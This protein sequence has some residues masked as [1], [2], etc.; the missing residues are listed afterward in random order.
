M[1]ARH[2]EA[3]LQPPGIGQCPAFEEEHDV[4]PQASEG[5]YSVRSVAR[6]LDLLLEL[7]ACDRPIGLSEL[8]RRAKLHPTT[9]LR[10]L[11]T[12]RS[13]GFAQQSADRSYVLG[14][15]TFE[16]GSAFL[17]NVSIWSQATGLVERLAAV[18]EETAS[19]GVLDEGQVLYIA[20][21]RGQRDVGI[22]SAPGSR[23]PLYCTSLGKAILAEL[24]VEVTD[25]LLEEHP[26]QRLSAN[27]IVDVDAF[28]RELAVI[29][30]RGYAVDD[31]E[32]TPGVVCVGASVHDH[33]GRPAGAISVSGPAFR[34]REHGITRLG[35]AVMAT[36]NHFSV[37]NDAGRRAAA[38]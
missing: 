10:L 8:A 25:Q 31:E 2:Q 1:Q 6:A 9:A 33:L 16:V 32:R 34:M 30:K 21:A 12:L 35:R 28:H 4:T 29:R 37:P 26:P 14:S 36:A 19:A 24:P 11:E 38:E 20:I 13:R 22:A 3:N 15:R 23:H 5:Q 17:S 18:T 7:A 27:T